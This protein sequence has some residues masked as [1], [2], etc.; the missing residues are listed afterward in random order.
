[1]HKA[2]NMLGIFG[3]G[4]GIRTLDP[5]LGNLRLMVR[6]STELSVTACR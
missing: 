6:I 2:L 1:M 3:A 4:E 5:N